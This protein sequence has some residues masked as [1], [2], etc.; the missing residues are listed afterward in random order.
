[1]IPTARTPACAR[2]LAAVVTVLAAATVAAQESQPEVPL[3]W[4]EWVSEVPLRDLS[5]E[6]R[7]DAARSDPMI[8]EWRGRPIEYSIIQHPGRIELEFRPDDALPT[9]RVYA[10]NGSVVHTQRGDRQVRLRAGWQQGGRVLVIEG[11]HW[12]LA[13]QTVSEFELRYEI[14]SGG[15]LALTQIDRYGETVWY[16]ERLR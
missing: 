7:F 5:G 14:A 9:R 15:L 4:G 3:R 1:M 16:F 2:V 8:E 11:R 6:W 10:W 12:T 13:D